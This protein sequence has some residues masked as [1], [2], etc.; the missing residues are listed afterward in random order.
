MNILHLC[1]VAAAVAVAGC[2]QKGPYEVQRAGSQTFLIDTKSGKLQLVQGDVLF[3]VS[4]AAP[5]VPGKSMAKKW[6]VVTVP[7]LGDLKINVRTTHRDGEMRFT[8]TGS[9]FSGPLEAAWTDVL[10]HAGITY[11]F[12]DG[13]GFLVTSVP[14]V[15]RGGDNPATRTVNEKGVISELTWRGSLPMTKEAYESLADTSVRWSGFK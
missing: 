2:D 13:D 11:D 14:L 4:Q 10:S 5:A 8:A 12:F 3:P 6:D 7:Q 15:V 1:L 9:P